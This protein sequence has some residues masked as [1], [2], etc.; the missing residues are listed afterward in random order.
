M[1]DT[2]IG[3]GWPRPVATVSASIAAVAAVAAAGSW[4]SH[5]TPAET[6]PQS[7]L[8][9]DAVRPTSSDTSRPA[10]SRAATSTLSTQPPAG[11][12]ESLRSVGFVLSDGQ[13]PDSAI[14]MSAAEKNAQEF[15]AYGDL[16]GVY[17]YNVTT[18]HLGT[19][20]NDEDP[21]SEVVPFFKDTPV[22][23]VVYSVQV[24]ESAAEG[25]FATSNDNNGSPSTVR[26]MTATFVNALT[27]D[28]ERA[29][30]Y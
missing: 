23:V 16:V 15:G 1:R 6:H 8:L 11:F 30:A 29:V 10:S 17:F 4:L 2:R 22:Y 7:A 19:S 9:H 5:P 24:A 20:V 28:T 26:K 13:E 12:V 25:P 3:R 27:G 18:P 14:G 21:N